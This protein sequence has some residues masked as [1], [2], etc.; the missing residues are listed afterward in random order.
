MGKPARK[1]AY[2][3]QALHLFGR[4]DYGYGKTYKVFNS[5]QKRHQRFPDLI[6]LAYHGKTYKVFSSDQKR[7]Q[8]FPDLI[9]LAYKNHQLRTN[10]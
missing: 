5:D 3:K 4:P 7:H 6:G 8:Q 1:R 2:Y 9:G 10:V